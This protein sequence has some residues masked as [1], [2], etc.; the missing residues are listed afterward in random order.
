M[1]TTTTTCSDWRIA[2]FFAI[3]LLAAFT[4]NPMLGQT[5]SNGISDFRYQSSPSVDGDGRVK[6]IKFATEQ[7]FNS[8]IGELRAH[9]QDLA[10]V[11]LVLDVATNSLLIQGDPESV[12]RIST[13]VDEMV[14]QRVNDELQDER[15]KQRA[16]D[17]L[18][19]DK[20]NQLLD[21]ETRSKQ[22]ADELRRA[23]TSGTRRSDLELELRKVLNNVFD[24]QQA[25]RQAEYT[26]FE[27]RLIELKSRLQQREEERERIIARRV[28]E[29][30]SGETE[31][32]QRS[33]VGAYKKFDSSAFQGQLLNLGVV[34]ESSGGQC[35][36][37][38]MD[39]RIVETGTFLEISR[40]VK[41]DE[42]ESFTRFGV[43]RVTG[44]PDNETI[45]AE[46]IEST[47]I[48]ENH[49]WQWQLPQLGD[50]VTERREKGDQ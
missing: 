20:L 38:L 10:N 40:P 42:Q 36:I 41:G 47:R 29:L 9:P 35:L 37:S 5:P 6:V 1:T 15:A 45:T 16:E 27:A 14:A 7:E 12:A 22:L 28:R 33:A 19:V 44:Q 13:V 32:T 11:K 43:L 39:P 8:V 34:S 49:R 30:L 25:T 17:S 31:D 24:A 21:L 23:T 46:L 50:N 48:L 3:A 18:A 4:A 2:T 26:Q